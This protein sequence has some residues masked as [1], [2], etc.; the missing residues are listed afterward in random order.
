MEETRLKSALFVDFDNVYGGLNSLDPQQADAM[1]DEPWKWLRSLLE[2]A[3]SQA[4]RDVLVKRAYLNPAGRVMNREGSWT[5][6]STIRPRLT[7]AGFEVIDCPSLTA[8]GKN[9]ADI[10]IVMDVLSYMARDVHYDEFIIASSDADF[11]PLLY[12]LRADDRRIIVVAAGQTSTAYSE[13][14]DAVLD[15][16]KLLESGDLAS[17]EQGE[18]VEDV[19]I[20]AESTSSPV[21]RS[22]TAESQ[23]AQAAISYVQGQDEPIL[24]APFAQDLRA[25]LGPIEEMKEWFG[26]GTFG[27][28][29]QSTSSNL[30]IEG[31]YVWDQTRHRPPEEQNVVLPEAIRRICTVTDLPRLAS[32]EWTA[33]FAVMARYARENEFNLTQCTAWCRDNL[34]EAGMRIGRA[35]ISYVVRAS[36]YG[37]QPL[38][39]DPTPTEEQVRSAVLQATLARARAISLNLVEDEEDELRAWLSGAE[40]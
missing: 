23:A 19:P 29:L 17:S 34:D 24:L 10:R 12:Q 30:V 26:Y 38:N 18:L 5:Y 1:A 2:R 36:L 6:F 3:G 32:H 16:G 15:I 33:L 22:G 7:R 31:H 27:K 4:R 28:F 37:G 35:Q 11:T 13:V 39:S 14:A 8:A 40:S 21:Q 25:L 20:A 9:A